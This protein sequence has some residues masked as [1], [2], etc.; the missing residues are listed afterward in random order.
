MKATTTY[1][2]ISKNLLPNSLQADADIS[3]DVKK[4][5]NTK[6][7]IW[8]VIVLMGGFLIAKYTPIGKSF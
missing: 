3:E 2:D 7:L 8:A 6:L 4:K 5:E 1:E